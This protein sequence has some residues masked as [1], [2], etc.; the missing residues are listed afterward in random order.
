LRQQ[1][2]AEARQELARSVANTTGQIEQEFNNRFVTQWDFGE[3]PESRYVAASKVNAGTNLAVYPG[4]EQVAG[5]VRLALFDS[6]ETAE[7]AHREGVAR[8]LWL[9]FPDLL[10]QNERDL[11]SKL[12]AAS[13]QYGLL[14]KGVP[15]FASPGESLVRDVLNAAVLAVLGC[16]NALIRSQSDFEIASKTA[17]PRLPEAVARMAQIAQDG[18]AAAL[19]IEQI[20][21][22]AP[23]TWKAAILDIRSQ[24][25]ELVFPGFM[26]RHSA[27]RLTHLPRYLKAIEL[28]INKL[29]GQ[30]ARDLGSM[31]EMAKLLAAWR[32]RRDRL[33]A[34]GRIGDHIEPEMEDFRW[35]LEELRVSL[36][37]QE[38]KT[39]EPVS[40]KRLEKRWTEIAG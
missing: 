14:F 6:T 13:L 19:R 37:A 31:N 39:P 30:L 18:I 17:R 28:R 2:G 21:A 40:V 24:L 1:L 20:L 36:F 15:G 8:L 25:A 38:L 29:P 33:A 34:Q 4:L 26:I 27:K 11:S 32:Q 35:R 9:G 3:L 10:R 5:Q 23:A 7:A 22:K 16:E 12:K